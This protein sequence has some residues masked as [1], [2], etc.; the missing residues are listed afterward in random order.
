MT[1]EALPATSDR[2]DDLDWPAMLQWAIE[3][4]GLRAVHQ[5]IADLRTGRVAGYE[6]LIRFVGY[7]VRH[8]EPWIAA[9]RH[10][11]CGPDLQAVALRVALA[12][13]DTLP[14]GC[15]LSV[16]VSPD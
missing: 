16:N 6:A 8:P 5:P 12:D 14:D 3:G 2:T 15:F 10:H 4:S 7:P 1:T 11:G 13:R 9:A